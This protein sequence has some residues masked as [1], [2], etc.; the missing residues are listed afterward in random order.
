ML[1]S[2]QDVCEVIKEYKPK[3]YISQQECSFIT[4]AVLIRKSLLSHLKQNVLYICPNSLLPEIVKQNQ[5][6]NIICV[7]ADAVPELDQKLNI[8]LVDG[9]FEIR[10]LYFKISNFLNLRF[11]L[12]IQEDKLI[13]AFLA[14]KGLQ[15]LVNAGEE[16]FK[17]PIVI[18]DIT[19]RV[20][21][22]SRKL[23]ENNP[24]LYKLIKTDSFPTETGVIL[25]DEIMLEINASNMPVLRERQTGEQYRSF[26]GKIEMKGK[27]IG[28]VTLIECAAPFQDGDKHLLKLFCDLIG[29]ELQKNNLLTFNQGAPYESYLTNLLDGQIDSREA[30]TKRASYLGFQPKEFLYIFIARLQKAAT[31]R[32]ALSYFAH[33]LESMI[34]GA[35]A[36]IYKD[37]IVMLIER[38]ENHTL[39]KVE[40]GNIVQFLR[41]HQLVGVLSRPFSDLTRLRKHYLQAYRLIEVVVLKSSRVLYMCDD[42]SLYP[43]LNIMAGEQNLK[44]YCHPLLYKLIN[45]DRKYNTN[46]FKDL[47]VYLKNGRNMV[48]TARVFNIHRNSMEYRI[49]RITDILNVQLQNPDIVLILYLSIKALLFLE[50]EEFLRNYKNKDLYPDYWWGEG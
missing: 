14:D 25:R 47:Y 50:G 32:M 24:K 5:C 16:I 26:T 46:F 23:K 28:F 40:M 21:A 30:I 12:T 6:V 41:K 17:N 31:A 11:Q 13:D 4:D 7:G 48:K 3:L 36:I 38:E 1:T 29:Y 15:Y 8:I 18:Q 10:Q 37:D 42:I 45:Y 27:F 34:Y 22:F 2:L 39:V 44:N 49:K 33:C 43:L 20:T 35:K 19:F 9:D